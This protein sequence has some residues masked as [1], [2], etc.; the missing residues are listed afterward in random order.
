[1]KIFAAFCCELQRSLDR[2]IQVICFK[3]FWTNVSKLA[4]ES[5]I[6]NLSQLRPVKF[7]GLVSVMVL[8]MTMFVDEMKLRR[9]S[10]LCQEYHSAEILAPACCDSGPWKLYFG[11]RQYPVHC[12]RFLLNQSRLCQSLD[13]GRT[14]RIPPQNL[15]ESL[16]LW[17]PLRH[18][19]I[20]LHVHV[21]VDQ[22]GGL[23]WSGAK[24]FI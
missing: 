17:G 20:C 9:Q 14:E 6:K 12:N 1:M 7:L 16:K 13:A 10:C 3:H 15:A 19:Y 22:T 2:M 4:G 11:C 21:H 23:Q 18:L 5:M 24:F 8:M